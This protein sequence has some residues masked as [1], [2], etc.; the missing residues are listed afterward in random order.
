MPSIEKDN[1]SKRSC[2]VA[3]RSHNSSHDDYSI[4]R[5]TIID[6]EELSLPLRHLI[7]PNTRYMDHFRFSATIIQAIN[8]LLSIF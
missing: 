8:F 1:L 3:D 4:C 7:D 5:S 6:R 2:D